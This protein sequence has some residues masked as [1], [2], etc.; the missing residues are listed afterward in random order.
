MTDAAVSKYIESS[1]WVAS[2]SDFF[3]GRAGHP[4]SDCT[5]LELYFRLGDANWEANPF[6]NTAALKVVAATP[7][8]RGAPKVWYAHRDGGF[9]D[10]YAIALL[11]SEQLF[12]A[13]AEA[14]HHCQLESYYMALLGV[15]ATWL[16]ICIRHI[17]LVVVVRL[18]VVFVFPSVC[19]LL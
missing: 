9:F 10:R 14:I 13:G 2:P 15:D 8:T 5:T 17:H 18:V 4:L 11:S 1:F 16:P 3:T 7:L 19:V 6:P 12:D